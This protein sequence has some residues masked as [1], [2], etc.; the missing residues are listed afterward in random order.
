MNA[1]RTTVLRWQLPALVASLLAALTVAVVQ[2]HPDNVSG[3]A[4]GV[5]VRSGQNGKTTAGPSPQV[6]LPNRGGAAPAEAP[7]FAVPDLVWTGPLSVF[8]AGGYSANDTAGQSL[9]TVEGVS[10]LGGRITADLVVAVATSAG[11]G[12]TAASSAAGSEVVNLVVDGVPKGNI[13]GANVGIPIAGGTVIVNQQTLGG[14]GTSTSDL[15]VTGLHVILRDPWTW[16]VTDDISI[17]KASSGVA[18]SAFAPAHPLVEC[19]F[20]TG[21]GRIDR[22][23][24]QSNQD[25]ATFGFNATLRHTTNCKGP[26]GQLQYVDHFRRIKFHGTSA[27]ISAEFEDFERGGKC[28]RFGGEG[29]LNVDNTGWTAASY[30]AEACDNGEPGVGRDTF[31]IRISVGYDSFAGEGKGPTLKGGNIQRHASDELVS[32]S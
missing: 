15:S 30:E 2:S 28:A 10:L 7:D 17:G 16:R 11:D 4:S 12:V 14:D 24:M 19:V 25:F 29:R 13:S 8:T 5:T 26:R 21:G 1:Q 31:R 27:D 20:Y 18:T 32:G 3:G 6:V 22:E 9:S 23:P